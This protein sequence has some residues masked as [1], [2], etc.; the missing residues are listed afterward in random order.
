MRE[1]LD[2][3]R[4]GKIGEGKELTAGQC[5][6][7]LAVENGMAWD[8]IWEHPGNRDLKRM[9]RHPN[10]LLPG[11][12]VTIPE[13]KVYKTEKDVDHIYTY[14]LT[15][16]KCD[17]QLRFT[18]FGMPRENEEYLVLHEK[19]EIASGKLDKNGMLQVNPP[20]GCS[21]VTV[22]IGPKKERFEFEVRGLAPV[23]EPRGIQQRLW[24]LGYF[25]GRLGDEFNSETEAAFRAFMTKNDITPSEKNLSSLNEK[26]K[27]DCWINAVKSGLA[28]LVESHGS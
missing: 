14:K 16:F 4:Y 6:S 20:R 1:I 24:N 27:R 8:K 23:T 3:I 5:L 17:L 28:L 11:D 12:R 21:S 19:T 10:L 18:V 13:R 25:H 7:S 9:R 26:E 22:L 2:S 15:P